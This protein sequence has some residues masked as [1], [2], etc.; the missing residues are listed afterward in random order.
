MSAIAVSGWSTKG[1][2]DLRMPTGNMKLNWIGLD[3]ERK[4][5]ATATAINF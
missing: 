1:F 4:A 3:E 2:S 5:R